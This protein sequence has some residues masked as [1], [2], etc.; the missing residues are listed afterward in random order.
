MSSD[1]SQLQ[2]D[3]H[4]QSLKRRDEFW[5]RQAELLSWHKK[6]SATVREY[7]QALQDGTSYPSWTW[8]PDGELSTC[9]NCVDRHVLAG[10][11]DTLA[12]CYDSPA[13]NSKEKYTYSQLFQEVQVLAGAL[14]EEGVKRGD[15]VMLYS[16][17][18]EGR[19]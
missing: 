7:Q 11:G 15:V 17:L 19:P 2:D 6:P 10:H 16:E 3:V 18:S 12:I 14:R 4:Q 1:K 8:F 9:F 5:T 13:T